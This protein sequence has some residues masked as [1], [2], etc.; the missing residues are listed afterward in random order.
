MADFEKRASILISCAKELP[1]YVKEEL[2]GL[3]F[4][5]L[6]ETAASIETA[7]TLLDAMALNLQLRT[8]GHVLFELAEFQAEDADALYRGIKGKIKWEDILSPAGRLC[9]DSSVRN[10]SIRDSR[11][12]NQKAKDAIVDRMVA[13][14]GERP[15]SGPDRKGAVVFVYWVESL[16]RVYIDTSGESLQKRG[17]R[18]IPLLAP[19][20][21]T[22]AA[23][24]VMASGWDG[25]GNFINPMCGSG[26]LA[27]EAALYGLGR[28]PGLLRGNFGFQHIVGFRGLPEERWK[29]LRSQARTAS[30]RSLSGRIIATDIDRKAVEAA[31]KN[32]RTAGVDGII[33]F[34]ICDFRKTTLPS[35]GGVIVMNPAYGE[36]MGEKAHLE[37]VYKGIGDFFKQHGTGYTGYILT[38]NPDLAGKVGLR[39]SRRTRFFNSNIECRLLRYELY[40]GSRKR[41]PVS[42]G[43]DAARYD[44]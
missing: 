30:A 8:A 16:C 40:E 36:R 7:G 10:S 14:L 34:G 13:K 11:F 24:I 23:A 3:G 35:G 21:E 44:R 1:H 26:T 42:T 9:V 6:S 19:L 37:G 12:A 33:D 5:V 15:D 32:A 29:A 4:P 2:S 25:R 18:K 43:E 39:T 27:I 31:R 22:L 17:Y 28:A 41:G 38:G 20:Q